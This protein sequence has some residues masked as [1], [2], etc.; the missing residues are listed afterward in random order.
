M[1]SDIGPTKTPWLLNSLCTNLVAQP[2][3]YGATAH[4]P[5][6]FDAFRTLQ[7]TSQG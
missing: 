2:S 7:D 1:V 5:T 4:H 3:A 6:F